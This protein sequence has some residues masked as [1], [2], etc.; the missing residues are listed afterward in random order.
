LVGFPF[1]FFFDC[2][3]W[4]LVLFVFISIF[5]LIYLFLLRVV[6]C[7]GH[8]K[9]SSSFVTDWLNCLY[10]RIR[11]SDFRQ[12]ESDNRTVELCQITL[13]FFLLLGMSWAY[14][15]SENDICCSGYWFTICC[16]SPNKNFF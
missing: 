9:S 5:L 8:P 16:C 2:L 13:F 4:N 11:F 6:N 7:S 15:F 14:Y 12:G 3:R 10:H 1:G